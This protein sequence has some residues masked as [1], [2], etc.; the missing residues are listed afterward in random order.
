MPSHATSCKFRPLGLF[1]LEHLVLHHPRE[2]G[3]HEEGLHAYVKVRGGEGYGLQPLSNRSWYPAG[4][5][6]KRGVCIVDLHL[7]RTF[8][9]LFVPACLRLTTIVPT[10]L[11]FG[12]RVRWFRGC[13]VPR[14]SKQPA[15]WTDNVVSSVWMRVNRQAD[16][17]SPGSEL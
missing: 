5:R 12:T 4:S 1:R 10:D 17:Q 2:P 14:C 9:A 13:R 11:F 8:L 6:S 7:Y 15:N 3:D 16:L